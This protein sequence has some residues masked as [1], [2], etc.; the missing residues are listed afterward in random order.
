MTIQDTKVPFKKIGVK[1]SSDNDVVIQK[2]MDTDTCIL[3]GLIRASYQDVAQRFNLTRKNCPKHPSNCKD[4]WIKKDL[5]RGVTYYI[6]F[7]E[8]IPAGCVA[9][10]K[11]ESQTC[12]LERLAVLPEFRHKGLGRKLVTHILDMAEKINAKTVSIGIIAKQENLKI[13][14]ETLGFVYVATKKF[15]HLPFQVGFMKI[16]LQGKTQFSL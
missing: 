15:D 1:N 7:K 5:D 13:W 8:G 14:Y 16:D 10:E 2:A 11:A 3:S 6:L 4:D 9:M 12:F